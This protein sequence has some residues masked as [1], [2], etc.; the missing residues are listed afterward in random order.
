MSA[1]Y[2]DKMAKH[3]CVIEMTDYDYDDLK[4]AVADNCSM[5]RLFWPQE[6]SRAV[7]AIAK[8]YLKEMAKKTAQDQ[9]EYTKAMFGWALFIGICMGAGKKAHITRFDEDQ[10]C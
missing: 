10:T 7:H 6:I 5:S 1:S 3:T 2:V 8:D 9:I 4:K